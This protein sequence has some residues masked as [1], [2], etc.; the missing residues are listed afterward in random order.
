MRLALQGQDEPD[1]RER[2]LASERII[3]D[4]RM[5][6]LDRAG[7]PNDETTRYRA[8]ATLR[9]LADR[10][11]LGAPWLQTW[12]EFGQIVSDYPRILTHPIAWR[13][14]GAQLGGRALRSTVGRLR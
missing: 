6:F 10:A 1:A 4:L 2:L 12:T 9:F 5:S 14:V 13:F 7:L 8:L 3:F 11:G